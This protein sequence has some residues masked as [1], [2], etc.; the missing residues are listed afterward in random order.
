MEKSEI[1]EAA[2]RELTETAIEK[3]K[4]TLMTVSCSFM[5]R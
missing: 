2:I 5:Q 4:E 3:R 1:F